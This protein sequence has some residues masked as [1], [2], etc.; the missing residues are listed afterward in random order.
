MV[1][2]HSPNGLTL[3]MLEV[4]IEENYEVEKKREL[5]FGLNFMVL[6]HHTKSRKIHLKKFDSQV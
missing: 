2:S 5:L 1:Q 4:L 3:S 6:I